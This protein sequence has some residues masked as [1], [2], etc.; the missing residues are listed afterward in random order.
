ML[1]T[2]EILLPSVLRPRHS[3]IRVFVPSLEVCLEKVSAFVADLTIQESKFCSLL[4]FFWFL[5]LIFC[6]SPKI[7]VSLSEKIFSTLD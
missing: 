3:G 5:S 6:F 4:S 1:L 7:F 2:D